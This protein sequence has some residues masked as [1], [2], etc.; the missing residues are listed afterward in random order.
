MSV[1]EI[2]N[3]FGVGALIVIGL[4]AWLGKVWVNRIREQDKAEFNKEL[5]Q[6]KSQLDLTKLV[7]SRYSEHQFA[8][9]NKLWIS[10]CDLKI[11]GDK[12]WVR[13]VKRI[14][15]CW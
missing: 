2:Y 11:A 3:Y 9:Y 14:G 1:L 12:L 10:L 13:R 7:L 5:E 6:Y 15:S 8:L 4:A